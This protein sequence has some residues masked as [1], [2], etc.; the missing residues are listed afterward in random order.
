MT[1]IIAT[2]IDCRQRTVN[3]PTDDQTISMDPFE[4]EDYSVETSLL[5]CLGLRSICKELCRLTGGL[6]SRLYIEFEISRRFQ[7]K[8]RS[9]QM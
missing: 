6:E 1:V 5:I 3:R 7:F 8:D 9:N 2:L 4:D